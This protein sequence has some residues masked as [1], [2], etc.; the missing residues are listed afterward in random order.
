MVN[1]RNFAAGVILFALFVCPCGLS[2]SDDDWEVREESEAYGN[3]GDERASEGEEKS[4]RKSKKKKKKK[5][6]RKSKKVGKDRQ[7]GKK[8]RRGYKKSRRSGQYRED[9]EQRFE[10]D[11]DVGGDQSDRDGDV[12]R[13]DDTWKDE[14]IPPVSL[15]KAQPITE[16]AGYIQRAKL[17]AVFARGPGQFMVQ[18]ASGRQTET[19]GSD[20]NPNG[21]PASDWEVS[22]PRQKHRRDPKENVKLRQELERYRQLYGTTDVGATDAADA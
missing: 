16:L 6:S 1:V 2:A 9:A 22:P 18:D 8:R 20:A 17:G 19:V 21:D 14:I 12:P 11:D 7:G 5:H 15:L 3:E 10:G 4:R 13:R